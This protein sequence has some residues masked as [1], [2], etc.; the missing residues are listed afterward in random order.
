MALFFVST[1][2]A[3][4]KTTDKT[5][6]PSNQKNELS[7][8][9]LKHLLLAEELSAYEYLSL[10]TD[11]FPV[12]P[13]NWYEVH[14]DALKPFNTVVSGETHYLPDFRERIC[15]QLYPFHFFF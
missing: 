11:F 10:K 5:L 1:F 2:S 14:I 9:Q 13:G 8:N 4:G 6:L 12:D 3:Y 15:K 7:S